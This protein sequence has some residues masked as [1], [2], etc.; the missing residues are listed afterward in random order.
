MKYT[1]CTNTGTFSLKLCL[2]AGLDATTVSLALE[3]E[4]ASMYC[5]KVP[6]TIS[7]SKD[8]AKQ[9]ASLQTGSK[10]LVVDLGGKQVTYYIVEMIVVQFIVF[11]LSIPISSECQYRVP[12]VN[13]VINTQG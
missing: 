13:Q 8:G 4:A 6:V 5:R 12:T 1:Q 2:Q 11:Y 7:T 3:P 10:Y 9:I